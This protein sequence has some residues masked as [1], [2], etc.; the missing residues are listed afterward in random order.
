MA[1]LN[2]EM[3][4]AVGL[5]AMNPLLKI[6]HALI[7]HGVL[8]REQVSAALMPLLDEVKEQPHAEFL[9]PAWRELVRQFE[10]SASLH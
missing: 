5:I 9:E 1:E 3:L 8:S 4:A 6:I 2:E 10:P 7:S